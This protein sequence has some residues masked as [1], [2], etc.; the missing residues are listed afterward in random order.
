MGTAAKAVVVVAVV[1]KLF[2][3]VR[4]VGM[5]GKCG[6]RRVAAGRVQVRGTAPSVDTPS[7]LANQRARYDYMAAVVHLETC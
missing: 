7:R 5:D 6:A 4:W 2:G 1:M 3:F